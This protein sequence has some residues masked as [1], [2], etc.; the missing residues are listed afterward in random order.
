MI[1]SS[2]YPEEFGAALPEVLLLEPHHFAQARELSRRGPSEVLQQQDYANALAFVGF[3]EWLDKKMIDP[4][5][6]AGPSAVA[7]PVANFTAGV[8][9]FKVGEFKLCLVT[10]EY[11]SNETVYVPQTTIFKPELAAHFY[12][13]LEISQEEEQ[14]ILRGV[15]QYDQLTQYLRQEDRIPM[16]TLEGFYPIPLALFD[17]DL[18]HLLSY[19]RYLDTSA[20]LLPIPSEDKAETASMLKTRLRKSLQSTNTQLKNWLQDLS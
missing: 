3:N 6:Q 18:N 4:V 9:Y 17:P 2:I 10:G 19:F 14:A 5:S 7:L 20:I 11:V 1:S 15:L 13:A 8:C 16:P 12:I